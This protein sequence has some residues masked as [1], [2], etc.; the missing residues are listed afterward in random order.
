MRIP[1]RDGPCDLTFANLGG[2]NG[3]AWVAQKQNGEQILLVR[4]PNVMALQ[5]AL[6]VTGFELAKGSAAEKV[7]WAAVRCG[8]AEDLPDDE[9]WREEVLRVRGQVD[10]LRSK[11][12]EL[13]QQLRQ[14]GEGLPGAF[15]GER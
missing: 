6:S 5:G 9:R 12:Y 14:R 7:M 3:W 1:F 11:N 8:F 13:R 10:R 2:E 15:R 4:S